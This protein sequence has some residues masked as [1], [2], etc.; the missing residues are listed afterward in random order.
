MLDSV[1][2]AVPKTPEGTIDCGYYCHIVL[3][4]I[5][6]YSHSTNGVL[7]FPRWYPH[8]IRFIYRKL[9]IK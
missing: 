3:K 9:D 4:R 2:L 5:G 8:S 6:F 7:P 1:R